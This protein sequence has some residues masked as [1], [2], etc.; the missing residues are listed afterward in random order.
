[1]KPSRLFPKGTSNPASTS[2]VARVAPCATKAIRKVVVRKRHGEK[3]KQRQPKHAGKML[4]SK[5]YEDWLLIGERTV[6]FFL[7]NVEVDGSR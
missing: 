4:L 2:E 1:M 3:C 5:K 7:R 6:G